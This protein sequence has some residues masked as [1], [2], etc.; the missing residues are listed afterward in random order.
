[1]ALR[2]KYA[3]VD[4]AALEVQKDL[5][6]AFEVARAASGAGPL[7]VLPTYTAMLQL[8]AALQRRGVVRGFWVD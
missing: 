2:L 7:Y 8:R 3:G 4:P 6:A 5:A 1:M